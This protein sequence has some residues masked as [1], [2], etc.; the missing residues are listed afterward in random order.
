MLHSVTSR[1]VDLLRRR[2]LGTLLLQLQDGE[3]A[4]N[5]DR[6]SVRRLEICRSNA[7]C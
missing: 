1:G 5:P 3:A 6:K 2:R 7:E 4:Q